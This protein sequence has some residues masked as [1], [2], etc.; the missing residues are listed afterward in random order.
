MASGLFWMEM[1]D[2]FM[3]I[4]K[5]LLQF[6]TVLP[7]DLEGFMFNYPK[8]FPLIIPYY[9]E[10]ALQVALDPKAYQEYGDWVRGELI[11]GF[12]KIKKEYESGDQ[13]DL[14]FLV[15]IDQRINKLFCF[16]FWIVNYLFADGPLHDYFVSNLKTLI[17]KIVDI[18]E[19]IEEYEQQ[20]LLIQRDL[21]QSDYADLYLQQALNGVKLVEVLQ[22]NPQ[23]NI[24]LNEVILLIDQHNLH[25]TKE[26][27][28]LWDQVTQVIKKIIEDK[29]HHQGS[30]L[31]D[32]MEIPLEQARMRNSLLPVYNMLTH[33]IE[34]REENK[35][36]AQ[37]YEAMKARIEDILAQA[38]GIL[39]PEEYALFVL[40]Y[41]QAR[42]FAM[43]KDI[44]GEMDG[45]LLPLWF[46]LHDKIRAWIFK[47]HGIKYQ[48]GGH[49]SMYYQLV[50]YL[51]DH[52]KA[53]VYTVDNIPFS[54]KTL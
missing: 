45:P 33:A 17:R 31:F 24:L 51:P 34:F 26:I 16:R 19:D 47:N 21:L 52:L 10:V 29:S 18:T 44:M 7:N 5:H 3:K 38:K 27:N 37:R 8:K 1:R 48:G 46:G 20:V 41:Q 35:Q 2:I 28:N 50:W 14:A 25:N 36:L 9:E 22:S 6:P 39:S 11:A 49:A 43:Y 40:S 54:I 13:E 12:E 15:D 42:N 30:A 32:L 23:T 53:K 4:D